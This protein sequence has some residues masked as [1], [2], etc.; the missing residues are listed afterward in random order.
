MLSLGVLVLSRNKMEYRKVGIKNNTTTHRVASE[1]MS[2]KKVPSNQWYRNLPLRERSLFLTGVRIY[3]IVNNAP[4]TSSTRSIYLGTLQHALS[5]S[6]VARSTAIYN[7]HRAVASTVYESPSLSLC[8]VLVQLAIVYDMFLLHYTIAC[9]RIDSNQCEHG[10]PYYCRVSYRASV[11]HH[12]SSR[13]CGRQA[14][15]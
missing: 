13:T 8:R 10:D 2:I 4:A 14:R 1:R 6:V 3:C 12:R 9:Q 5:T 15:R 11:H 7:T